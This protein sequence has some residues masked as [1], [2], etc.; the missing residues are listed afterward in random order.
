LPARHVLAARQVR[1]VR[2]GSRNAPFKPLKE[3]LMNA[4]SP[5]DLART[6]D[7]GA[8]YALT[9][10]AHAVGSVGLLAILGP[11]SHLAALIGV[12]TMMALIGGILAVGFSMEA[13]PTWSMGM[14]LGL[15]F[16]GGPYLAALY[17]A[18]QVGT[19]A[20]TILVM[21]SGAL[22]FYA[23]VGRL[24]LPRREDR[25]LATSSR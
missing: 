3:Q 23:A 17:F 22:V 7:L 18:P 24:G 25:R 6:P 2:H 15:P 8:K 21:L 1:F 13:S 16:L 5:A 12:F 20:G 4:K 19:A 10:L 9:L 11:G 14:V